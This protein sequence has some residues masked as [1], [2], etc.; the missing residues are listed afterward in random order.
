MQVEFSDEDLLQYMKL[1]H[2]HDITF[3][4]MVEIALREAIDA[5]NMLNDIPS[6]QPKKKKKG[7]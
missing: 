1:A 2:E 5:H 3:N 4:Q 6:E 7:N